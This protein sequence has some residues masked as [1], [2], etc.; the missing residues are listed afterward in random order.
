MPHLF[1]HI[2]H[3]ASVENILIH[4]TRLQPVTTHNFWV[5]SDTFRLM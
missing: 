5:Y 3:D 4:K 2:F 1:G